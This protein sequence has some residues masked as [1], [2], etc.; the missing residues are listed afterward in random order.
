[1]LSPH[2]DHLVGSILRVA[3]RRI[4]ASLAPGAPVS[5]VAAIRCQVVRA[6]TVARVA[7]DALRDHLL[8]DL[9]V[10]E[11]VGAR[12]EGRASSKMIA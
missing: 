10:G 6:W 5:T 1:M 2:I 12:W 4:P 3:Q 11:R 7:G 8:T 9:G